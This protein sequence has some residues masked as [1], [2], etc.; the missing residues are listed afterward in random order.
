MHKSEGGSGVF[1]QQKSFTGLRLGTARASESRPG[2]R[3][4]QETRALGGSRRPSNA[5]ICLRYFR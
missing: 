4:M 1:Q 2:C 3:H 5:I